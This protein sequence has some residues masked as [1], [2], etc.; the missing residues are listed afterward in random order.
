MLHIKISLFF[1]FNA[2]KIFDCPSFLGSNSPNA[3]YGNNN[4]DDPKDLYKCEI[5]SGRYDMEWIRS[6]SKVSIIYKPHL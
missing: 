6:N 2:N 4:K 1:I 3:G 5:H